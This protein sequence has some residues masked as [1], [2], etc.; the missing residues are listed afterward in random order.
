MDPLLCR[1]IL[2]VDMVY[3]GWVPLLRKGYLKL[4][5]KGL[6][7]AGISRLVSRL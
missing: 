4:I 1:D 2:S 5:V 6:P 7:S 3:F